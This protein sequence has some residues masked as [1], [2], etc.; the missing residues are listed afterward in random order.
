MLP[1]AGTAY[2]AATCPRSMEG[3]AGLTMGSAEP[4]ATDFQRFAKNDWRKAAGEAADRPA[5]VSDDGI[6]VGP[7]YERAREVKPI[8]GTAKPRSVVQRVAAPDLR[9]FKRTC[10]EALAGGAQG[11]EVV[12]QPS[13]HPLPSALPVSAAEAVASAIPGP[14][15]VRLDAG[16]ETVAI[17]SMF[18]EIVAKNGGNLLVSYD[19]VAAGA[20]RG[21]PRKAEEMTA[22]LA[23]LAGVEA[24][25]IADGRIWHAAGASEA[26]ELAVFLATTAFLIRHADVEIVR[27]A[28][29]VHAAIAVDAD[30][31]VTIAKVRSAR[32]LLRRLLEVIGAASVEPTIHAETAWRMMSRR[33]PRMNTLR[34]T[35]AAFSAAVGGADSIAVLP[36]DALGG[37][38]D[39]GAE[40]LVRNT[41]TILAAEAEVGR[42]ADP[43]AGSGAIEALTAALAEAAWEKFRAIEAEG[44]I[45]ATLASGSLQE[46][47]ATVR[48][49]RRARVLAGEDILIGVNAY[50]EDGE[51]EPSLKAS[52]RADERAL[53]FERLAEPFETE[54]R[55]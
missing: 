37:A 43:G 46:E 25:A 40:R 16:D 34:T 28:A 13:A 20:V 6:P 30:R 50:V 27:A 23:R 9:D 41:Q 17:A 4:F 5:G 7:L 3:S 48:E 11:L 31:F 26:Q 32:I 14:C 24:F 22:A 39:A 8:T 35:I 21:R 18:A 19:P 51:V 36:F 29:G 15:Q 49:T 53:V 42:V 1:V 52:R 33:E 45:V 44:G 55:A 2:N 47:I 12:F 54:A 10:S 38:S